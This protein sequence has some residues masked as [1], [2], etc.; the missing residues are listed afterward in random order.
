MVRSIQ[1]GGKSKKIRIRYTARRK[2]G[3]LAAANRLRAS[4]RSLNSVT[5]ELHV[6]SSNLSRWEQEKVGEMDPKDKLF[7]SKQMSAHPGPSSQLNAIEEP[8]LCYGFEQRE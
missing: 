1:P 7:K 5:H 3:L 8:L 2:H 6:G 4:G